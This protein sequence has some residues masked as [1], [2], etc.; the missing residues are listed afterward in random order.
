MD[1]E[2]QDEELMTTQAAAPVPVPD[3]TQ[4]VI[5]SAVPDSGGL[6]NEA[7]GELDNASYSTKGLKIE[8]LSESIKSFRR[9]SLFVK[10]F[11]PTHKEAE[12][13]AFVKKRKKSP[14]TTIF[15]CLF[16]PKG[17]AI[18]DTAAVDQHFRELVPSYEPEAPLLPP[19]T[20][21]MEGKITLVLD[22]DETLVH[23][24]FS[25][26]SNYD[27]CIALE[28]GGGTHSVYVRKRPRVDNFLKM[29]CKWYEVVI[30]TASLSLYANPV[31][32]RLDPNNEM[33]YRL[34]REHCVLIGGCYVKDLSKLGRP[35]EKTIII[36]NSALSYCLQPEQAIPI[37]NFVSD[38]RDREL[39]EILNVLEKARNLKDVRNAYV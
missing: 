1:A 8:G 22:L 11:S 26:I 23:S 25:P 13:A 39:D 27:Y 21:E 24:S 28:M 20:K 29:V 33:P 15:P 19:Q 17:P 3:S 36:D 6:N 32:D 2:P 38:M 35:A 14:F 34:Y 37:S 18:G 12:E 7:D 10:I 16:K 5:H 9:S 31:C 4:G 30:F